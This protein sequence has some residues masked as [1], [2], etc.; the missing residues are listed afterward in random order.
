M[1]SNT[2]ERLDEA[3]KTAPTPVLEVTI[4]VLVEAN[5]CD[6]ITAAAIARLIRAVLGGISSGAPLLEVVAARTDLE[7][8]MKLLQEPAV[9]AQLSAIDPL[10]QAKIRGILKKSEIYGADGGCVNGEAAAQ[11]AGGITRSAIDKARRAGHVLGLPRGKDS[12][13][14]P[15]WQFTNGGYLPGLR[16]VLAALKEHGPWVQASFLLSGHASLNGDTPLSRLKKHD[17]EPVFKAAE[18]FG[19][20]VPS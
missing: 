13:A 4:K 17:I 3:A 5:N 14:Y 11:L 12:W 8:L 6:Q 18:E 9:I 7:A 16:E 20:H 10:A 2:L 19:E 1:L 15:V